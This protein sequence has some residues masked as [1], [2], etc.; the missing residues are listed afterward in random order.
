MTGQ[1]RKGPQKNSTVG[2]LVGGLM[3]LVEARPASL[4][5]SIVIADL[6]TIN[7]SSAD[8]VGRIP[9]A[10]AIGIALGELVG[11]IEL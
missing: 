1:I 11:G 3:Y 7:S 9:L 8:S 6:G 5:R 4:A 10:A 2:S